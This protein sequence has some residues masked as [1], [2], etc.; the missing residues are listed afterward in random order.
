MNPQSGPQHAAF[1]Q[2]I[3][4]TALLG[5][6]LTSRKLLGTVEINDFDFIGTP[7]EHVSEL[8]HNNCATAADHVCDSENIAE[9]VSDGARPLHPTR[10]RKKL[11][12]AD[13]AVRPDCRRQGIASRLLAEVDSYA[14]TNGYEEIY[15]HVETN[16]PH[17]RS[18]YE[19]K[20]YVLLPPHNPARDGFTKQHLLRDPALYD[21]L[22]KTIPV[23]SQSN[24]SPPPLLADDNAGQASRSTSSTITHTEAI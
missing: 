23:A 10:G 3:I 20:G 14:E 24:S 21:M 4:P 11:Y 8:P 9:P 1:S 17:A 15:L 16:N 2:G 19:K 7:M 12:L 18:L 22:H 13:L 6:T 5:P